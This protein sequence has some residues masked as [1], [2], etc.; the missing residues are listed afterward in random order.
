ML[1]LQCQTSIG[2]TDPER[3]KLRRAVVLL[4]VFGWQCNRSE[5]MLRTTSCCTVGHKLRSAISSA[6]GPIVGERP[7]ES[8]DLR[9]S[10][11][12]AFDRASSMRSTSRPPAL[13][14]LKRS[15]T[16]RAFSIWPVW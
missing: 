14:P 12:G 9:G 16:S 7:S 2:R 13:L 8:A 3:G 15:S 1:R 11:R 6:T 5:W 10:V 4:A